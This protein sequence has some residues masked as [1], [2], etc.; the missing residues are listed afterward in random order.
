M[1]EFCFRVYV[2]ESLRLRAE[3]KVLGSRWSD[4]VRPDRAEPV[5]AKAVIGKLV[6]EG[7]LILE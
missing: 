3:G 4:V 6:D 2:T 7:G 5:D 1:E